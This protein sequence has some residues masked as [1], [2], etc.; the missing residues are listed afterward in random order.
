MDDRIEWPTLGLLGLAY[1]I[2]ALAVFSLASFSGL[3]A[4]VVAGFAITLHSSLQHEVIHGHP[5]KSDK[6]NA[7][8]VW[9]PLTLFIPF[10]RFRDTHLAHHQDCQLTDPYDDP[11]TN[12]LDP[13]VWARIPKIAQRVLLWNNTL[14]GRMV[15]GPLVGTAFFL[16]SDW[17]LRHRSGVRSGWLWHLPGVAI[18]LAV[19]VVSP[20][21]VWAY[22]VSCYLAL[23]LLRL[24][25]FLEHRAHDLV[26]ARSV[27][28]E[29]KGPLAL[30]F[31]NNNLHAVHHMHPGVAW[32]KLPRLLRDN[33]NRFLTAND[34]YVYESYGEVFR[35][36]FLTR[37]DP[38]AHPLWQRK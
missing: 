21:S 31:L 5:F 32:Y 10:L 37:K 22:L 23:S 24:R 12:F 17:R 4:V 15:I 6:L 19:V 16:W 3:L 14:L 27:I 38:V 7:L 33:R 30:L 20:M 36:Y 18:V 25:T 13:L 9:P 34:G 8:L 29:D 28:V 26:R 35:R 1:G 11:E 2:W